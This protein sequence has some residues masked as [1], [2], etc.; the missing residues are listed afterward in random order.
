MIT[1]SEAAMDDIRHRSDGFRRAFIGRVGAI[2]A[3]PSPVGEAVLE[4][5]D[6]AIKRNDWSA[7]WR[8]AFSRPSGVFSAVLGFSK[9]SIF[10]AKDAVMPLRLRPAHMLY[11]ARSRTK[12]AVCFAIANTKGRMSTLTVRMDIPTAAMVEPGEHYELVGGRPRQGPTVLRKIDQ[13]PDPQAEMPA[14]DIAGITEAQYRKLAFFGRWERDKEFDEIAAKLKYPG[15]RCGAYV[16]RKTGAAILVFEGTRS[17]A[18]D[19]VTNVAATRGIFL[20]Q[21]KLAAHVV[22]AAAKRYPEL[23]IAG[24]SKGGGIAQ[25]AAAMTGFPCVTFNSV[26]LPPV[27]SKFQPKCTHY[28]VKHD[29]VSNLAGFVDGVRGMSIRL[30]SKL[31]QRLLPG[32]TKFLDSGLPRSRFVALHGLTYC[33]EALVRDGACVSKPFQSTEEYPS[34]WALEG[35]AIAQAPGVPRELRQI[36]K[37]S[38]I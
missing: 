32:E 37:R 10:G 30:L 22:E 1:I 38:R 3:T 34:T 23:C 5:L 9:E 20:S 27:E 15:Q 13:A 33:R 31:P 17:S 8:K 35:R 19:M 21:Y 25:Y 11:P 4:A 36:I 28:L 16:D 18:A 2:K 7:L 24:H 12:A 14:H 6:D 29:P 26:G